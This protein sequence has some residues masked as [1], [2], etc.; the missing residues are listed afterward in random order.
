MRAHREG[1]LEELFDLVWGGI[2]SNIPIPRLSAHEQIAHA[3]PG[4]QCA[5]PGRAQGFY[6]AQGTAIYA[7]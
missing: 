4:Q 5:V 7:H 6:Y 1:A 3:T 2:G